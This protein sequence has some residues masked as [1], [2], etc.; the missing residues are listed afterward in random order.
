MTSRILR[1]AL[2]KLDSLGLIKCE[3]GLW[4]ALLVNGHITRMGNFFLEYINMAETIWM[5]MLLAPYGTRC[6]QLHDD[7]RHN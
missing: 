2:A 4:P 1:I 3:P 5:T 7:E 6:G